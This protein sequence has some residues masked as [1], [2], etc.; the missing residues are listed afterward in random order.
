MTLIICALA[1]VVATAAT[2]LLPH[3]ARTYDIGFLALIYGGASLMWCVDGFM[4][5]AQGGSFVELSNTAQM[6]DDARLG[7]CVIVLG[8]V[9]WAV[10]MLLVKRPFNRL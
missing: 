10:R 2:F 6:A 3:A 4:S 5:L 9:I 7:A 8:L 1:A